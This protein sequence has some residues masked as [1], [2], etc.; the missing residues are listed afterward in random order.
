MASFDFETITPAQAASF[1]AAADSLTFRSAGA[2]GAMV[3]VA[4]LPA[5]GATPEQVAVTLAG[6]TVTF[7]AGLEGEAGISF[8][9]GSRL[10]VGGPGA[11]IIVGT[12][13]ADGLFGGLGDDS[14]AGGP[15]NDLLQGN[16][17]ADAWPAGTAMTSSTAAGTTTS[18]TSAAA[19]TSARAT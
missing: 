18:S 1:D 9:D 12:A 17:G 15:G 19:R 5:S 14:I 3:T 16:Q 13:L 8:A 6:Q 11:D 4:Y 7:G 10:S 2:T